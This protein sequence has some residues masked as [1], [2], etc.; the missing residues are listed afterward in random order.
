[1]GSKQRTDGQ[2]ERAGAEAGGASAE[3][4]TSSPKAHS[5]LSLISDESLQIRRGAAEHLLFSV[6]SFSAV[7]PEVVARVC[8][9]QDP[10]IVSSLL[11][12]LGAVRDPGGV[13]PVVCARFVSD[14]RTGVAV[15]AAAALGEISSR[16]SVAL[17]PM[18]MLAGITPLHD[19]PRL[20]AF[21]AGERTIADEQRAQQ[22]VARCLRLSERAQKLDL[23]NS[24][25]PVE[26]SWR[27]EQLDIVLAGLCSPGQS[28]TAFALKLL[29]AYADRLTPEQLSKVWVG[30]AFVMERFE[31]AST[32]KQFEYFNALR[33]VEAPAELAPLV[34]SF[35][36]R[37][38]S[39]A[40][41]ARDFTAVCLARQ[42]N[43][44]AA[45]ARIEEMLWSETDSGSG[46]AASNFIILA[47]LDDTNPALAW[48]MVRMTLD[49]TLDRAGDGSR[50]VREFLRAFSL[51]ENCHAHVLNYCADTIAAAPSP[52]VLIA[53]A[54][55]LGCVPWEGAAH[56]A[57]AGDLLR[58]LT[59][60][61]YPRVALTATRVL[62]MGAK[63]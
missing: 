23:K 50:V 5:A 41:M 55:L 47:G 26:G 46:G 56:Q 37:D 9:E 52:D 31:G 7:P 6:R 39:M 53:T 44:S 18:A 59:K 63:P 34:E 32:V 17:L 15:D 30:L 48:Q 51:L 42:G 58:V 8:Q 1:M 14:S 16:S 28:V 62:A 35:K 60:S 27:D 20:K 36:C 24:T 11:S 2:K 25:H 57:E 61:R 40:S 10:E 29:T 54:R 33:R 13:A 38:R 22:V 12:F 3:A 4:L 21:G 49:A 45:V 43:P 19:D